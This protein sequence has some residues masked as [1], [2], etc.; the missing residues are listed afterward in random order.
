MVNLNTK[1]LNGILTDNEIK[2]YENHL[3]Q[4]HQVI[5]SENYPQTDL[6][7][8]MD[9]PINYSEEELSYIEA[10]ADKIRNSSE[11]LVIIGIG[12]SYLGARAAVEFLRSCNYN[13]LD[14]KTPDIFFV[15]NNMSSAAL[16]EIFNICKYKDVVLNVVSKSGTTLEC[17]VTFRLFKKF[18]EEKYGKDKAKERI[19]CTTDPD[20]GLLREMAVKEG[21]KI[22]NIPSN[23]G[24][25]YSVLTSVGLLPLSV[26]GGNIRNLLKGA[27]EARSR[28]LNL[29]LAKNECY[30]YAL[31]RNIL[32]GRGKVI[33]IIGGY[34]PRLDSFF[35]WWKQL[36]GESE[37]KGG[38]GIFPASVNFTT[39]L[40]SM[41]QFIQEGNPIFFETIITIKEDPY[42]LMIPYDEA[43]EDKLNY[44]SNNTLEFVNRQAFNAVAFAH[45]NV[46][47]PIIHLEIDKTDEYN[48]GYLIYFFEKSCAISAHILGVDP[49]NQPGVEAYKRKM[50]SLLNRPGYNQ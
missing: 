24:G 47:T 43:D 9:L 17:M 7:G 20:K 29:D 49:F 30:K 50:F 41:G 2:K 44:L 5:H 35:E 28:F 33:E 8:W 37:G 11:V 38:K 48:L 42:N 31:L 25:R 45:F 46:G 10:E 18:L 15:G 36:F 39:D 13:Y 27:S 23:I 19:Y 14:K 34:E 16:S 32:Y 22:F 6:R 3:I 40:H 21:Y 26:V 4:A 1:Y 12:G